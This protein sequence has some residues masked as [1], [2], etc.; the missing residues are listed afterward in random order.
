[1]TNELYRSSISLRLTSSIIPTDFM[2]STVGM[3]PLF[4]WN[5]GESRLLPYGKELNSVRETLTLVSDFLRTMT[6]GWPKYSAKAWGGSE[7]IGISST[8]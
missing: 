1:M 2:I 3:T 5:K 8:S 6:V 7:H 4:A